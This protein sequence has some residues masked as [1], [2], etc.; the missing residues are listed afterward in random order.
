MMNKRTKSFQM[1]AAGRTWLALSFCLLQNFTAQADPP[2]LGGPT[3]GGLTNS[4]LLS[5]TNCSDTNFQYVIQIS[6]NLQD[7][8]SYSTNFATDPSNSIA[9]NARYASAYYR[10]QIVPHVDSPMF[11]FSVVTRSNFNANGNN[12]VVDSFDSSTVLYSTAGQYDVTKHKANGSIATDSTIVGD[13]YAGA[14]NI[15]GH[16]YTGPGQP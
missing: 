4:A 6:T 11:R 3:F 9:V 14:I 5:L 10:V 15:Y 8:V 12:C 2:I 1:L 16:A 7:W 13:L